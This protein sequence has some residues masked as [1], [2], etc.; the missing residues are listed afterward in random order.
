MAQTCTCSISV[1]GSYIK[2]TC[3]TRPYYSFLL[4]ARAD[5]VSTNKEAKKCSLRNEKLKANRASETEE[6]MKERLRLRPEKKC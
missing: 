4:Y 5:L 3:D 1:F 2:Q 6:Q